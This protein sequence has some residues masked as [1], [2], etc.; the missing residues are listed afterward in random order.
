LPDAITALKQGAGRLIRDV[1]DHGVLMIGDVRLRR[2]SYGRAFL[3]SLPPMPL[4]QQLADVE[5]FFE[6]R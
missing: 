2:K 6:G 1:S 4:T 3:N 5:A